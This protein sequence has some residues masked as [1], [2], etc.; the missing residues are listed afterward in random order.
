MTDEYKISIIIPVY[1]VEEY[2]LQCLQSVAAQTITERVECILIDDCGNDDSMKIVESFVS[3]YDGQ[4]DFIILHHEKNRGLSAA[5]NS[6][7][8]ASKGEYLFF[9]DS[10][11]E[12]T[13]DCISMLYALAEKFH[14]DMVQG[15]YLGNHQ[16]L[17][18]Y[19]KLMPDMSEDRY[20]IK[21]TML[22]Y[23]RFPVMAQ[24]RLVRKNVIID[25][26]VYFKEGI[27]HE[28]NHWTFF[29]AKYIRTLAIC[30][31]P[32]YNYRITPGSITN[33]VD[34]RKEFRNLSVILRDFCNNYDS[35]LLGDQKIGTLKLLKN[36]LEYQNNSREGIE[37][38]L[39]F[40]LKCNLLEKLALQLWYNTKNSSVFKAKFFNLCVRIFHLSNKCRLI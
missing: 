10:D 11:D 33:N 35:F 25:N 36:A 9:L 16:V 15:T 19:S 30:K 32:S 40:Y 4:I 39:L 14:A 22:D 17:S 7:I 23:D 8:Q 37:L 13:P 29:L 1:H 28:D 24:N 38:F 6:G 3:N 34:A 21:K 12:I 2:I 27:I 5:R 31:T 18:N 26:E 20:F